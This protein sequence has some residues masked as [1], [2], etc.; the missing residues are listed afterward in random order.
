MTWKPSPGGVLELDSVSGGYDGS[1]V[2]R[3][4]SLRVEAGESVA[5]LGA[6]GSG[7]TTML[8]MIAGLHPVS[9]GRI[10]LDGRRI[11][12]LSAQRRGIGL[13]PQQGALFPH[14]DV[15]HNVGFGLVPPG[16]LARWRGRATSPG[17]QAAPGRTPRC[18]PRPGGGTA[19][20]AGGPARSRAA[21]H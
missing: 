14:L 9:S 10:L 2:V 17:G 1:P 6:S 11:D 5:V 15:A 21:G 12:R 13:V 3:G 4:V 18:A 8:R 16:P 20:P 19:R 7:K